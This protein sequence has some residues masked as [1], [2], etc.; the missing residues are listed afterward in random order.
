[1]ACLMNETLR[2]LHA[3]ENRLIDETM[4]GENQLNTEKLAAAVRAKRGDEGLRS[5]AEK[6]GGV[7]AATLSRIEQGKV[8]DVDTF[9]RLCQW[10]GLQPSEFSMTAMAP[11]ASR[12]STPEVIEAHL[13]ADRTLSPETAK[14][15]IEMVRLAYRKDVRK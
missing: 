13:R 2:A 10:L 6:I 11:L 15:L 4:D 14:T 5:T 7:S 12:P 9:L 8:P 1:M 3:S